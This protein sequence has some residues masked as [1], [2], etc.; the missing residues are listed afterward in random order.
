M[1]QLSTYIFESTT[2]KLSIQ[3]KELCNEL[4]KKYYINEGGCIYVAYLIAKHLEKINIK[5]SVVEYLDYQDEP[6]HISLKVDNID[7][8]EP[9]NKYDGYSKEHNWTSYNLMKHNKEFEDNLSFFWKQKYKKHI[10]NKIDE[11]FEN[12]H[13]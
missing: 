5:Y 11:V 4:N 1:K 3:L 12:L 8:N 7:I 10:R 6:F 2:K 13:I 9:E